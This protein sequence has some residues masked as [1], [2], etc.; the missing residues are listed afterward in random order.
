MLPQFAL[1]RHVDQDAGG[2][3]VPDVEDD[4]G[5]IRC[6]VIDRL[7]SLVGECQA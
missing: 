2:V 3:E 4:C 1:E 6:V 5:P 7:G